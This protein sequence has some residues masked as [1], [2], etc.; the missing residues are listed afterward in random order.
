MMKVWRLRDKDVKSYFYVAFL[1]V[2]DF[3][4]LK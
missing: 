2:W 3:N 4:I 1:E